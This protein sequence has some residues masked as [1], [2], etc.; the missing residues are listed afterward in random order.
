MKEAASL[1][2][3]LGR[4][5]GRVSTRAPDLFHSACGSRH[6]GGALSS[7]TLGNSHWGAGLHFLTLLPLES[8]A[9][10]R[11][12]K[13]KKAPHCE[14]IPPF[15]ALLSHFFCS[16]SRFSGIWAP[17]EGSQAVWLRLCQVELAKI[18]SMLK[19]QESK[20]C[21]SPLSPDP[22]YLLFSC[23]S[24]KPLCG[25]RI[26]RVC[27]VTCPCTVRIWRGKASERLGLPGAAHGPVSER[28]CG[29]VF[30]LRAGPLTVKALVLAALSV[31]WW[32][33]LCVFNS[34]SLN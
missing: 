5:E 2:Q 10:S 15:E 27:V 29:A 28:L 23:L 7:L 11:K 21:L 25:I 12:K 3:W 14:W 18:E 6:G 32:R 1:G 4:V 20:E 22:T 19:R 8:A 16:K 17:Q 33:F 13:K 30:T 24:L 31:F 26:T 34:P 9:F